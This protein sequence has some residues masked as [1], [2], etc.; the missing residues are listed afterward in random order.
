MTNFDSIAKKHLEEGF[1]T[2]HADNEYSRFWTLYHSNYQISGKGQ[3]SNH[4]LKELYGRL[5][6]MIKLDGTLFYQLTGLMTSH[7]S[8]GPE[9]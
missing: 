4:T 8:P 7:K 1:S 5:V 6:Q 9:A 3:S 2:S